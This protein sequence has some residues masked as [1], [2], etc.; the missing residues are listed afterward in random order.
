MFSR[1]C[2]QPIDQSQK[3]PAAAAAWIE[4][5]SA[6]AAGTTAVATSGPYLHRV[7]SSMLDT[8]RCILSQ[9][10][11][12]VSMFYLTVCHIVQAVQYSLGEAGQ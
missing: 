5:T 3:Q 8:Q 7:A 4:T 10:E 1:T 2:R 9:S 12:A 11:S 6:A